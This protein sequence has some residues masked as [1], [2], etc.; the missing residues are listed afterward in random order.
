MMLRNPHVRNCRREQSRVVVSPSGRV[1]AL[2]LGPA[3]VGGPRTGGQDLGE[4]DVVT[5]AAAEDASSLFLKRER[6]RTRN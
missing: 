2:D 3:G 4:V 1:A 5:V 6:E